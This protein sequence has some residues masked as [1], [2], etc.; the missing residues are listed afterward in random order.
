MNGTVQ[1][2]NISFA[3]GYG[4]GMEYKLTPRISLRASGDNI[5]S[6]FSF[7]D[8]TSAESPHKHWNPRAGF[9]AVYR[10]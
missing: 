8:N 6:S 1:T 7:I 4:G 10:F 9:G 2:P 5:A 3:G